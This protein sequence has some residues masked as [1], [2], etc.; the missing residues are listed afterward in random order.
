MI[1]S[2]VYLVTLAGIFSLVSAEQVRANK[3]L[4]WVRCSTDIT[5]DIRPSIRGTATLEGDI[6]WLDGELYNDSRNFKVTSVTIKV[7]GT[8][9]GDREFTRKFENAF[10]LIP[11][12]S[13]RFLIDLRVNDVEDI[14]WSI[15]ELRGC[16]SH[17]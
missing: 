14:E 15:L 8:Y 1:R 9:A 10:D 17:R 6:G 4:N 5:D 12:Y 3:L 16:K 7:T 11:G 13:E 2:I